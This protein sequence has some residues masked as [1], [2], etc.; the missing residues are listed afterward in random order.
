MLPTIDIIVPAQQGAANVPAFLAKL[1]KMVDDPSTNELISW[2]AD[3]RSFVIH[4]QGAFSQTLL[5][6]YYKHSNLSSF[7]RQLN[8]YDFHKVCG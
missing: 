4:N 8:M 6:V 2:S 5:P 1:W 3:G 7:V